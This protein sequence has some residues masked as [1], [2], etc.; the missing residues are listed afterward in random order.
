MTYLQLEQITGTDHDAAV[1]TMTT[2]GYA[3]DA[4]TTIRFDQQERLGYGYQ[5]TRITGLGLVPVA[6]TVTPQ[7]TGSTVRNV[8]KLERNVDIQINIL[9]TD[10]SDRNA[11]MAKLTSILS[12]ECIL[13]MCEDDGNTGI[14]LPATYK[15]LRV[16][17]AGGGTYEMGGASST[18]DTNLDLVITLR[19]HKPS[20]IT[21]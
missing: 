11:R 12:G 10:L 14:A 21:V 7:Q 16:Y 15:Y 9:A 19:A 4:A 17:Y 5:A 6:L 18:T 8:R 3:P 1:A 13:R 20:F 2:A